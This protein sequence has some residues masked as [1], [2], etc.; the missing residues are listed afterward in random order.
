MLSDFAKSFFSAGGITAIA[1]LISAGIGAAITFIVTKMN[2]ENNLPKEKMEI[3]YD[4]VYYPIQKILLENDYTD[5]S[6]LVKKIE[7]YFE[8]YDKYISL[9]TKISFNLLK[10]KKV[11]IKKF[12][13]N[14]N[15]YDEYLRKRLGYLVSDAGEIYKYGNPVYKLA[16]AIIFEIGI[17]YALPIL[18]TLIDKTSEIYI[19]LAW[20]FMLLPIVIIGQLIAIV[21]LRITHAIRNKK[22]K[23][24]AQDTEKNE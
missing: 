4:E 18:G 13:N 3:A 8:K 16:L 12:S 19:T 24:T 6:E 9:S 22:M 1:S 20:L 10:K 14:I 2:N 17:E 15:H 11:K 7:P 5:D 23:E 21:V